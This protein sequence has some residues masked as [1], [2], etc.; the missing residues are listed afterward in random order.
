M[1]YRHTKQG[2]LN[3]LYNKQLYRTKIK[4]LPPVAYTFKEFMYWI[5]QHDDR[6]LLLFLNW[7]FWNYPKDLTPSID[8]LDPTKGYAL[9]NIQLVTWEYN[10]E[11]G[12]RERNISLGR[13]IK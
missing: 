4:N 11:K 6:F 8:R 5:E 1:I 10:N 3:R 13:K 9:D 12:N 7:Q 2:L